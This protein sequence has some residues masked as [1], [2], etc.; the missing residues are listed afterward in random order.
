MNIFDAAKDKIEELS[1]KVLDKGSEV[2]AEK[3][4]G[5]YAEQIQ[6]ARDVADEKIGTAAAADA[7]PL[8]EAD[9]ET[10]SVP[11]LGA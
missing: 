10:G 1:D 2:A 8:P 11:P 6:Q 9:P 4:G 3:A 5:D 7:D